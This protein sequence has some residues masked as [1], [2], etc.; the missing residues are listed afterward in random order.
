MDQLSTEDYGAITQL[1]SRYGLLLDT[2]RVEEWMGLFEPG[3]EVVIDDRPPI[4]TEEGRRA[5][6]TDSPRGTHLAAPPVVRVGELATQAVSEQTFIF[7]NIGSGQIR[8]GWY[9]DNFVKRDNQWFLVRREINF[10]KAT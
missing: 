5:L 7:F 3:A 8:S 6:I 2:Q 1:L 4:S 10:F 9:D